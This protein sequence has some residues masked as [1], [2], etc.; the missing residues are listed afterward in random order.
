MTIGC[1][2]GGCALAEASPRRLRTAEIW[3]YCASRLTFRTA[4]GNYTIRGVSIA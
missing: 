4:R 3:P 2:G 1:A